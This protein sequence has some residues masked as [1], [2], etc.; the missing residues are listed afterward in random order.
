MTRV[1]KFVWSPKP[2][3]AVQFRGPE[4]PAADSAV[5]SPIRTTFL[6][7]GAEIAVGLG[8]AE[9]LGGGDVL[10]STLRSTPNDSAVPRPTS[11]TTAKMPAAVVFRILFSLKPPWL[12]LFGPKFV[13]ARTHYS[14]T[15]A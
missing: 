11:A 7:S 2:T 5:K 4:P 1:G 10:A 6:G 12:R 3:S 13:L 9:V 14:R 8:A 15:A